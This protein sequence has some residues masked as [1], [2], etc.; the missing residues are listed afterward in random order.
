MDHRSQENKMTREE[1]YSV[2]IKCYWMLTQH[3]PLWKFLPLVRIQ[4][5]SGGFTGVVS[6]NI[7]LSCPASRAPTYPPWSDRFQFLV[8]KAYQSPW[9]FIKV[10]RHMLKSFEGRKVRGRKVSKLVYKQENEGLEKLRIAWAQC[11]YHGLLI[12]NPEA[13]SL[14]SSCEE[15]R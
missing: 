1:V 15:N 2:M 3:C 6:C 9:N 12:A 10:Q 11:C 8:F 5:F 7:G 14:P 4:T 13:N